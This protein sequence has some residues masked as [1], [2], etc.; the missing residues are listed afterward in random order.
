M[1]KPFIILFLLL[2]S[3]CSNLLTWHLDKGIHRQAKID[4]NQ[5]STEQIVDNEVITKV[6]ISATMLWSKSV[7]SGLEGNSAY[8]YQEKK[9]NIIFTVDT[10]GL[11]SAID[12]TNGNINWSVPTNREVSSGISV[13]N[14]SICLG[15][16]SAELI[17][18][19]INLLASNQHTP[20]I[21]SLSNL[22]KFSE[23]PA[24]TKLD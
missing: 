7:N 11:L 1:L 19:N 22:T 2:M 16:S 10:D 5:S 9:N 14:N 8:L 3:S 24:E 6:D 23:Y 15:T 12:L 4:G 20:I 17:C 18:H 13:I 21:T